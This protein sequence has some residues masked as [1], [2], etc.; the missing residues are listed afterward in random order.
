MSGEW[1][2][3]YAGKERRKMSDDWVTRDRLLT[4]VHSDVRNLVS[5]LSDH[6]K[7]DDNVQTEIKRELKFHNK[8]IYGAL[9]ILAALNLITK[10]DLTA[11]MR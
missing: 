2:D 6:V 3:N 1:G 8:I 7:Q 11:F 5:K 4:E 10:I 9:G